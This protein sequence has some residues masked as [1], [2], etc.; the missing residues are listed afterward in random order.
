[1]STLLE[2][3]RDTDTVVIEANGRRTPIWA[4]ETRGSAYIRS[5]HGTTSAWYKRVATAGQLS[6]VTPQGAVPVAISLVTD[7]ATKE[8]VDHAYQDKYGDRP[9]FLPLLVA[10]PARATTMLVTP[11]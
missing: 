4:V 10:P 3:L 9:Q 1:M 7:E 2:Y 5:S 8:L 6:F 11:A